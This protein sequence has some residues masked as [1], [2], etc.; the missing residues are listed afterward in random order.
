[1]EI[2]HSSRN[3]GLELQPGKALTHLNSPVQTIIAAWETPAGIRR[4]QNKGPRGV[5]SVILFWMKLHLKRKKEIMS[6]KEHYFIARNRNHW[7]HWFVSSWMVLKFLLL[8]FVVTWLI[9]TRP[10]NSATVLKR[11]S[12]CPACWSD[13][14]CV[15]VRQNDGPCLKELTALAIT[16][17]FMPGFIYMDVDFWGSMEKS[18]QSLC[19]ALPWIVPHHA[20]PKREEGLR[21]PSTVLALLLSSKTPWQNCALLYLSLLL[22]CQPDQNQQPCSAGFLCFADLW[23]TRWLSRRD[24]R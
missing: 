12:Y 2:K 20:F 14:D 3:L 13:G 23:G 15:N 11:S 5:I 7:P 4:R 6:R 16:S 1:M 24:P 17:S 22:L 18:H 21:A 19:L 9:I 10:F 8:V